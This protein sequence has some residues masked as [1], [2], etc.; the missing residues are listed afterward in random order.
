MRFKTNKSNDAAS[1]KGL[2]DAMTVA[3]M[4]NILD[5]ANSGAEWTAAP[6][7]NPKD[8]SNEQIIE[9]LAK[10]G[11][12]IRANYKDMTEAAELFADEIVRHMNRVNHVTKA[13]VKITADKQAKAGIVGGMRKAMK[14]I[15]K[16]MSGRVKAQKTSSGTQAPNVTEKYAKARKKKW[17]VNENVVYIATRQ[18]ATALLKGTIKIYYKN[19]KG[20]KALKK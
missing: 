18:L 1:V 19:K 7:I 6:R 2:N 20:A 5:R 16:A 17:G 10:G 9:Y 11:R 13:G 8:P 4:L 15:A 14:S 12:D 3:E